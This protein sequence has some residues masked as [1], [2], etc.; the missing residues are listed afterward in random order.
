MEGGRG[1]ER[2]SDSVS[3]Q[4]HLRASFSDLITYDDDDDD[5]S[6]CATAFY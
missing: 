4:D 2:G 1:Q 5:D 3:K 6:V